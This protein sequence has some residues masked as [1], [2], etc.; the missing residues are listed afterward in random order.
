MGLSKNASNKS[1][2]TSG[3]D[4]AYND[5]FNRSEDEPRILV[6]HVID[7]KS[8]KE[9]L[10]YYSGDLSNM[11]DW[12]THEEFRLKQK[13]QESE[14]GLREINADRAF[15]FSKFWAMFIGLIIILF[16]FKSCTNFNLSEPAFLLIL[17]S[18][19]ASIFTFYLLVLKYLFYFKK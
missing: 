13:N 10:E 3:S 15:H 11:D 18:L 6:D 19:T 9:M 4:K 8:Q 12:I 5:Y 7:S 1:Y 2:E 14:R 17:G 16:G